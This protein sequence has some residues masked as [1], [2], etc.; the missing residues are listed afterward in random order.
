MIETGDDKMD[1]T[2]QQHA[3]PYDH[4]DRFPIA[5][6]TKQAQQLFDIEVKDLP[7]AL[8]FGLPPD[9]TNQLHTTFWALTPHQTHTQAPH[10]RKRMG[11][12]D[13]TR[14]QR[15]VARQN[16]QEAQEQLG[17]HGLQHSTARQ[18][19]QHLRGQHPPTPNTALPDTCHDRP[20]QQP[21]VYTDGSLINPTEP[22]FSLGGA[23]AWHPNR[24]L[25]NT[26]I[27]EA[28]A[29][30][31]VLGQE[32]SGLKLFTQISGY[33]GS[34]T[35]M[36]IAGAII[37]IAAK[38]AVHLGT[39]SSS[40]MAKALNIHHHINQHTL[41]KRPWALQRDGDL[42]YMYYQHATAKT[43]TAITITKVKGH[44]TDNM[45]DTGQVAAADK[46]G[47]DK[48]DKAADEGV[49]LFGSPT[50]QISKCYAKRHMAYSQFVADIHEHIAF[51]YRVRAALLQ[52]TTTTAFEQRGQFGRLGFSLSCAPPITTAHHTSKQDIPTHKAAPPTHQTSDQPTQRITQLI[53]VQ[54]CPHLCKRLPA[55]TNIQTFLLDMPFHTFPNNGENVGGQAFGTSSVESA[56]AVDRSTNQTSHSTRQEGSRDGSSQAFGTPSVAGAD[57]AVSNTTTKVDHEILG[58]TWLELYILY[59]MAGHPEPLTY[60]TKQATMRPTMR[61][62]IHAFRH[63]TRQLVINTMPQQTHDLFRGK[64]GM[65]GK[66][67]RT[68]GINTNLAILPWQPDITQATQQRIAQEVLRSQHRLSLT[69]ACDALA[70]G[71]TMPLRHIQL[72]GR[73][74][75]SASIKPTKQPLYNQPTYHHT[76]T[77]ATQAIEQRGHYG[78]LGFSL[79]CAPPPTSTAAPTSTASTS[80]QPHTAAGSETHQPQTQQPTP[81]PLPQL[82]FFRCPRCPHQLPGT[83]SAF[84]HNNLDARLWCNSCQRSLRIN[85]W[86]CT[87]GLPWHQCPQHR[88]EPERLRD[89][90]TKATS[91][92]PNI[93]PQ[94]HTISTTST[95][96][97]SR[98][99][100]KRF[101]GTGQDQHISRWLD[102]PAQKQQ[103][104]MPT[105]IV[106]ED[107]QAEPQPNC[108]KRALK[109]HLLGPKLLAK[110]A[111]FTTNEAGESSIETSN[112]QHSHCSNNGSS[113]SS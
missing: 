46:L 65:H 92:P 108:N 109:T 58:T 9:M 93:P 37:G 100:T 80:H 62:Q 74:K 81:A 68:L 77:S 3:L 56:D 105:H 85:T 69:Q 67:L 51:V 43:T 101:L 94:A 54:Q 90:G 32:G 38:G 36:E 8:R 24:Q 1:S 7:T 78:R 83:R 66:R 23:G 86:R 33:G 99:R 15:I 31:A 55:T 96:T 11:I 98:T 12:A 16:N 29:N 75:W 64:C 72:K 84:R 97:N 20:P 61:Q 50:I 88:H 113:S 4:P 49:A 13:S 79:S 91:T 35:R 10:M 45:V 44:A 14:K 107:P 42:W 18:A 87:C 40:F 111:R 71:R 2:T 60:D 34:S 104:T 26:G 53:Q 6:K 76:T 28:E 41:P 106:L 102:M 112:E 27:S 59:R 48:A 25:E 30:L 63:A 17:E 89:A 47:N 5:R 82:I 110:L 103:R 73:V 95:N 57:T 52:H 22:L 39:D 70:E 21:N 19:F